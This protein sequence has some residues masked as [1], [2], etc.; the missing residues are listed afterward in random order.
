MSLI[1]TSRNSSLAQTSSKTKLRVLSQAVHKLSLKSVAESDQLRVVRL[2]TLMKKGSKEI[3]K[4]DGEETD[5]R[6]SNI[7][8]QRAMQQ[9]VVEV[10]ICKILVREI[11]GV[12]SREATSNTSSNSFNLKVTLL[13]L[14]L[15]RARCLSRQAD[16]ISTSSCLEI[17]AVTTGTIT[18]NNLQHSLTINL[19]PFITSSRLTVEE[20]F[21]QLGDNS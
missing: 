5:N 19:H 18:E 8:L 9:A 3:K 11:A 17:A 4:A 14:L 15:P 16:R 6:I 2:Q 1:F 13:E 12:G 20:L 21:T 7:L 10:A